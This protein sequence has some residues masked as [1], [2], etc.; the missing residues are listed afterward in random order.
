MS[1]A[2]HS[3]TAPYLQD[4][5]CVPHQLSPAH[6]AHVDAMLHLLL[7]ELQREYPGPVTAVECL[8]GYL[9]M[10]IGNKIEMHYKQVRIRE[11]AAC[12]CK[13]TLSCG[14]TQ[15]LVSLLHVVAFPCIGIM[16]DRHRVI[17]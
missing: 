5:T 4:H 1:S 2:P 15:L 13:R 17:C 11:R 12:C 8:R 10:A 7:Q 9:L 14:Q 3:T 6:S 16:V